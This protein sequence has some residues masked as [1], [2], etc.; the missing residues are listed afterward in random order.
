MRVE[1][2]GVLVPCLAPPAGKTIG[3]GIDGCGGAGKSTLGSALVALLPGA[4]VVHPDDFASWDESVEWWQ[5]LLEQVTMPLARGETARYLRY[6]WNERRLAEWV[7]GPCA[8]RDRGGRH[9][10]PGRVPSRSCLQGLGRLPARGALATCSERD[11]AD[12]EPLWGQWMRDE[13]AH[14]EACRPLEKADLCGA[15]SGACTH[16]PLVQDSI[17]AS[18]FS[19]RRVV[20]KYA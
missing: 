16:A 10:D 14:R 3:V 12:A 2:L 4:T 6:D 19:W 7:E 17:R 20:P 9:R 8:R 1:Q 11:G 18:S 5:R 15:A 13:D